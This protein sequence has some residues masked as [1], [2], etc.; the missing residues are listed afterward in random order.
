MKEIKNSKLFYSTMVTMVIGIILVIISFTF[1]HNGNLTI[2]NWVSLVIML[3]GC[4][5][6]WFLVDKEYKKLKIKK[7][8][9]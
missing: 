5:Q 7:G 1:N 6:A 2:F 3:L 4:V 8:G 9:N